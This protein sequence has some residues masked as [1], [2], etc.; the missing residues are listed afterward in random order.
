MSNRT[1]EASHR[2]QFLTLHQSRLCCAALRDVPYETSEALCP[3]DDIGTERNLN[4][5]LLTVLPPARQLNAGSGNLTVSGS[6]MPG[7]P[8]QV[9]CS[10]LLRHERKE[11]FPYQLFWV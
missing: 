10:K 8:S 9:R 5:Y 11:W 3:V 6:Y 2:S 4:W 7:H 1:G